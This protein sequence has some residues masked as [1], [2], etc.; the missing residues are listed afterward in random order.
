MSIGSSAVNTIGSDLVTL[1]ERCLKNGIPSPVAFDARTGRP[2]IKGKVHID[3]YEVFRK[4]M[5]KSTIFR[6]RYRSLRLEDVALALLGHGKFGDGRIMGTDV[7]SMPVDIQKS[8]VLQDAVLIAELLRANG[9]QVIE[10]MKAISELVG[11]DLE[12]TCH[13]SLSAWWSKVFDDMGCIPPVHSDERSSL[14][15]DYQGGFVIEPKRGLY[16]GLKVVDVVS[17][18]P[19]MAILNNISFDTVNCACCM[20]RD[21]AR[22]PAE[23]IDKGYWICK[24]REG[25]FPQ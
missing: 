24:Q 21:D 17:L 9:G 1:N 6:N 15:F 13:T 2:Y 11:L 23:I 16:R 7:G 12:Q 22:V 19:S 20:N 4:E 14:V 8:Y 10:L 5:M 18:Y 3:L 25:A